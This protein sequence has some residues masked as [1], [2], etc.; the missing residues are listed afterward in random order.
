M[1][2]REWFF[3]VPAGGEPTDPKSRRKACDQ[4][5]LT[6]HFP[7][8]NH[9]QLTDFFQVSAW[10]LRGNLPHA[11]E[12]TWLL[13]EAILIDEKPVEQ[14]PMFAIKAAYITA[15]SRSVLLGLLTSFKSLGRRID[16]WSSF[17]TGLL[18][19][20]QESKYKV[21]MY[22]QAQIVG[23]PA[24]FV[25]IRHEATHGDMPNLTNLRS[26]AERA[27]KWLW[28]DYWK[29]LEQKATSVE[30]V[31]LVTVDGG[32]HVREKV[33]GDDEEQPGG[34]QRWQGRWTPKP[35]GTI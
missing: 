9:S 34:W 19:S 26:A 32:E 24:L 22:T 28:D 35:I 5:S 10:K 13:T 16:L 29:D 21:S 33:V 30:S 15:I 31:D 8:V 1:N 17:V 14:M 25:D 11:V 27:L 18:D 3:P 12:S 6:S 4:V 2:V 7:Y 23:L 20:Q